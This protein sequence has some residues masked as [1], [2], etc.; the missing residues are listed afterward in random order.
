MIDISGASGRLKALYTHITTYMAA[1]R[2]AK[3]DNCDV[4][5]STRA[6]AAT[7]LSTGVWSQGHADKVALIVKDQ[8]AKPPIAGGLVAPASASGV[9]GS[10]NQIASTF[11]MTVAAGTTHTYAGSG[12]LNLAI[13]VNASADVISCSCTIVIDGITVCNVAGSLSS[14]TTKSYVGFLSQTGA[15]L[16]QIPFNTSLAITFHGSTGHIKYRKTS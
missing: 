8:G 14:S 9:P 15:A 3:I 10:V 1:A 11:C 2:M 16:D 13:Q 6:P 5:N 12:V 4:A 7:A